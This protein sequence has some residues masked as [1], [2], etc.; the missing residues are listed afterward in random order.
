MAQSS[1]RAIPCRPGRH[2]GGR[3]VV[4][5]STTGD[6]SRTGPVC[7]E[8]EPVA[9]DPAAPDPPFEHAP[10]MVELIVELLR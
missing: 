9:D 5:G 8:Q 7:A 2:P 1:V 6:S 4:G 3:R 10:V